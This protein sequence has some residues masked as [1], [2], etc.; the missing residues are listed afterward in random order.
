[1]IQFKYTLINKYNE[2]KSQEEKNKQSKLFSALCR[3]EQRQ[4]AK[5]FEKTFHEPIDKYIK[6]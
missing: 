2:A 3:D 4:I 1:M 5:V 6:K